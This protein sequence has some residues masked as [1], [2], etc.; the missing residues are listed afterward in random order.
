M[1]RIDGL[2]T[3]GHYPETMHRFWLTLLMAFAMVTS[4]LSAAVAEPVCPMQSSA[5]ASHD[6]CDE[7]GDEGGPVKKMDGCMMGQTCRTPPTVMP[8]VEPLR[9]VLAAVVI[10]LPIIQPAAATDA[11]PNEFW[12]PPRTA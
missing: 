4:G 5:S 1:H 3:H 2:L 10:D 8:T 7:Q 6:C 9:L 11:R 12:R